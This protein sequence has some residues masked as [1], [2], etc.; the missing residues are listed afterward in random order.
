MPFTYTVAIL[1]LATLVFLALRLLFRFGRVRGFWSWKKKVGFTAI[2]LGM[3]VLATRAP[4]SPSTSAARPPCDGDRQSGWSVPSV[5]SE[6][7]PRT[8]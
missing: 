4:P 3:A 7:K 8:W 1:A 5:P 6:Q 2:L